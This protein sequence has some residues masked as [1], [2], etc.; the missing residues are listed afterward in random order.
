M[1][2]K[3]INFIGGE[4][5][6]WPDLSQAIEMCRQRNIVTGLITN[7]LR[8][9]DDEYWE[10]YQKMPCDRISLSVK[11]MNETEFSNATGNRNFRNAVKGIV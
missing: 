3:H 2:V 4:P 11:S 8:F 5:T 10:E 6:L 9:S 1:G 7:G